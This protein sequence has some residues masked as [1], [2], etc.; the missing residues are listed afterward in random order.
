MVHVRQSILL[1][2]VVAAAMALGVTAPSGAHAATRCGPRVTYFVW[3]HG[4]PRVPSLNFGREPIPHVDVVAGPGLSVGA[5]DF[6]GWVTS[7]VSRQG[8]SPRTNPAC[9]A[10]DDPAGPRPR[11]RSTRGRTR[12]VCRFPA[13]VTFTTKTVGPKR[14]EMRTWLADGS[15]VALAIAAPTRTRVLYDAR[16]CRTHPVP[17]R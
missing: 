16:S 13:V 7:G 15:L 5:E 11:L 10:Y 17:R 4:H 3:P 1:G 6:L 12:L 8:T 9:L 2:A 14:Q